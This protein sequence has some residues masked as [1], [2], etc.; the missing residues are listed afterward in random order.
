MWCEFS[1]SASCKGVTYFIGA[2]HSASVGPQRI[3]ISP[4]AVR[5][6][7]EQSYQH[8]TEF[9]TK[10][11]VLVLSRGT[12]QHSSPD[13]STHSLSARSGRSETMEEDDL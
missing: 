1:I 3:G 6:G 11:Y 12:A 13:V 9:H 10:T 5:I 2:A 8:P 4:K 7:V